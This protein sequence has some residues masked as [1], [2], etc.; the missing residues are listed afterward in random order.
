MVKQSWVKCVTLHE[1][2]CFDGPRSSRQHDIHYVNMS[3]GL[4]LGLASSKMTIKQKHTAARLRLNTAECRSWRLSQANKSK[5]KKKRNAEKQSSVLFKIRKTLKLGQY[6][7]SISSRLELEL[8]TLT[9]S[10]SLS[11]TLRSLFIN[12]KGI[13]RKGM[14]LKP[15]LRAGQAV[16]AL[17]VCN[18]QL[19][20]LDCL[21]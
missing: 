1:L 17:G 10:Y 2:V 15:S 16:Q 21:Q 13:N 7:S 8:W 9:V 11:C 20:K 4:M 3:R 5:Q 12:Q 19:S 14:E 18:S 6:L